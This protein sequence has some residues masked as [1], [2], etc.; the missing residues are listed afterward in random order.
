MTMV[1]TAVF[2]P[3]PLIAQA[4]ISQLLRH[5]S[6]TSLRPSSTS[7]HTNT[8]RMTYPSTIKAVGINK[9]GDVDVIEDLTLPFPE[10]KPGELLV[11]VCSAP[12]T[13]IELDCMIV[14]LS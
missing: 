5:F 8:F 14:R 6:S 10:Q 13:I 7:S 9:T 1:F 4:R 3:T 2:R 12:I 11:K